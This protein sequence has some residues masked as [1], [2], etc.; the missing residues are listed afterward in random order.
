MNRLSS[1][2]ILP[3]PNHPSIAMSLQRKGHEKLRATNQNVICK[4]NG[5]SQIY[6]EGLDGEST[7][8]GPPADSTQGGDTST[9]K[10]H[11]TAAHRAQAAPS[12]ICR[13]TVGA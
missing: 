3:V 1:T 6:N 12:Q 2:Q 5:C 8:K 9:Q 4:S 13:V 7:Y 11:F 10:M